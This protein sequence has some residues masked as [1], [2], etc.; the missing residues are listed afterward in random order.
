MLAGRP[1]EAAWRFIEDVG[2]R[3]GNVHTEE[4][5]RRLPSSRR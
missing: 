5:E 3:C 4:S 2:L 1:L